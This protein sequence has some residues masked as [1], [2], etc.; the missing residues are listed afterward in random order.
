MTDGDVD[1]SG[2][3]AQGLYASTTGDGAALAEMQ[4]GTIT[5]RGDTACVA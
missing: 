2:D 3:D 4:G 5:T 1:T